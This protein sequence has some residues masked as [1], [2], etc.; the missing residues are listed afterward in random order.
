VL[1]VSGILGPFIGGPLSDFC[2]KRGGP[3]LTMSALA[4]LAFL[5]APAALF[6]VAPTVPLEIVLLVIFLTL[7]FTIATSGMTV[8][9]V[10]IPPEIRG[11]YLGLS[12]ALAGLLFVGL[13]PIAV[14]VTAAALGG[15]RKIAAA[16]AIVCA[17]A[18]T[19]GGLIFSGAARFLTQSQL[20]AAGRG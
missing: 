3:K 16:L 4:A 10:V 6:A 15:E 7:G 20:V 2:Q 1:L 5:S 11:V 9:L 8:S 18:V 13:A 17:V 19:A 14:S 12:F